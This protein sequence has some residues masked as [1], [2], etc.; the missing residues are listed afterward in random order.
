MPDFL[1][2]KL[3][4]EASKKGFSG[5]RADRYVYGTMNRLG[6]MRGNKKTAKGL[7]MEKKHASD[8]RKGLA[9]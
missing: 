6:A 3:E 7:A 2:S 5:R 4:A 8:V 9:R 1:E